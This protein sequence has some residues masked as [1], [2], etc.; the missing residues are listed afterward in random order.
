MSTS[1]QG[2]ATETVQAAETLTF[3]DLTYSYFWH[4]SQLLEQLGVLVEHRGK[5]EVGRDHLLLCAI[6]GIGH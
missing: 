1:E 3:I 6:S 2:I 5:P 4:H